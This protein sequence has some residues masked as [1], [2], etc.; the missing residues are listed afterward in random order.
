[1]KKF[2]AVLLSV[3]M[4]FSAVS[5]FAFA[6]DEPKIYTV[7]FV[8]YNGTVIDTISAAE[9]EVIIAPA[10]PSRPSVD[11]VDYIFSGWISSADGKKYYQYQ[12]PAVTANVTYT[13]DYLADETETD[14]IS[15]FDFI[16][17]IFSNL[18]VIFEQIALFFEGINNA[19]G[20]LFGNNSLGSLFG[21]LFGN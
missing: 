8:D 21:N 20:S 2:L 11:S 1:M 14:I 19:L 17:N 12:I 16:Q 18:N 7:T 5:V 4:I 9:G 13:A 10:N 15:F 3:L 6:E